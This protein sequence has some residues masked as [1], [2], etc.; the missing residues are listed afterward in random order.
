MKRTSAFFFSFRNCTYSYILNFYMMYVSLKSADSF[1][2]PSC[3]ALF[4]PSNPL[5]ASSLSQSVLHSSCCCSCVHCYLEMNSHDLHRPPL[6][7]NKPTEFIK[8]THRHRI[9]GGRFIS[10]S[11]HLKQHV[12]E[13][14]TVPVGTETRFFFIF[15]PIPCK[16]SCSPRTFCKLGS[17]GGNKWHGSHRLPALFS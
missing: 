5:T 10:L 4:T 11:K 7:A 14:R 9:T 17:R 1:T 2:K 8:T 12:F 6:S 13:H 3:S 16:K 15:L